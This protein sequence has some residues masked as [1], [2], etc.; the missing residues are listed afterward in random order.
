[1]ARNCSFSSRHECCCTFNVTYAEDHNGVGLL[2]NGVGWVMEELE[3]GNQP[4]D[5]RQDA[6]HQRPGELSFERHLV[7][8]SSNTRK[9]WVSRMPSM[10]C[11]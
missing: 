10:D 7:S 4:Q 6:S 2:G 1:M 8:T 5:T 9:V 11:S 3:G